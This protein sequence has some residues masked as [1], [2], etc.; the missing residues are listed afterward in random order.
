RMRLLEVLYGNNWKVELGAEPSALWRE[1]VRLLI[2]RGDTPKA[3]EV[4]RRVTDQ[5]DV[6]ALRVDNR[7][8]ALVR[9]DPTWFEVS[10]AVDRGIA[11]WQAIAPRFPTKLEPTVELAYRYMD[12]G[13]FAD[14]L[15]LTDAA[16]ARVASSGNPKEVYEDLDDMMNW[17]RDI[18]ADALQKLGRWSEAEP[19]LRRAAALPEAGQ[20]N[21]SNAIN[22]AFFYVNFSRTDEALK[23]LGP[24]LASGTGLD[25]D[26]AMQ[27]RYL[28]H[29]IAVTRKN[30]KAAR[31]SRDYMREHQSDALSIFQEALLVANNMD[32]AASLAVRRLESPQLRG[33]MLMEIQEY[34]EPALSP[35]E[36]RVR[37]GWRQ[38]RKRPDVRAAVAKVG[39]IEQFPLPPPQN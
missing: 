14:A 33:D 20:P 11:E 31:E 6:L 16:I 5:R 7:F 19:E 12:C 38:L 25:P 1:Y 18:R 28:L 24:R 29:A 21:V 9:A 34:R 30:S 17:I 32:E 22:L 35:L 13:R 39:R 23:A 2:A 27:V 3:Q 26:A 15:S 37:D 4:L 8:E 36:K 10:A